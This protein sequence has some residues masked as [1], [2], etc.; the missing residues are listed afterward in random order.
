[1]CVCVCVC[2]CLGVCVCVCVYPWHH[3]QVTQQARIYLTLSRHSSLSFIVSMRF[4]RLHPVVQSCRRYIL[5]SRPTLAC[6]CEGV[7]RSSSL[8]LQQC[9]TCFVR[10]VWMV[11]E[12][13][14]RWPNNCCF[15]RYSFQ[16]LFNIACS[17]L[18]QFPSSFSPF[19]IDDPYRR[20]RFRQRLYEAP[21]EENWHNRCMEEIAFYF[22]G[23]G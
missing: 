3:Q 4:S 1:M 2:V 5:L 21:I 19:C 6:P 20:W 10:L 9:L 8:L 15:V 12:I 18:V 17:I 7:H 23:E 11:L 16:D 14:G 22:I 13:G